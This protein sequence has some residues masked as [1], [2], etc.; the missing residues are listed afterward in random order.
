M[1]RPK[2]L[3][4]LSVVALLCLG[5]FLYADLQSIHQIY[6]IPDA[7]ITSAPDEQT[8]RSLTEDRDRRNREERTHKTQVEVAMAIDAL[9]LLLM[10]ASLSRAPTPARRGKT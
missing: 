1:N 2:I 9:L 6:P 4:T 3:K 10:A 8:R 5:V 7:I